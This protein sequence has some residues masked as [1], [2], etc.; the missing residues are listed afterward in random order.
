M[1]KHKTTAS[2]QPIK[3]ENKSS[4]KKPMTTCSLCKLELENI[5]V[6]ELT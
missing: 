3:G 6:A 5:A 2:K 4:D 1:K